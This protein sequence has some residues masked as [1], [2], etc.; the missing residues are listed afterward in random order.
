M[1]KKI[2]SLALAAL[3]VGACFVGCDNY[4]DDDD[5]RDTKSSVSSKKDKDDDDEKDSDSKDEDY[6]KDKMSS[7]N[8]CAKATAN[9]TN[10]T[11]VELDEFGA[12][13]MF[14]GWID[15]SDWDWE[16]AEKYNGGAEALTTD[17]AEEL[18]AGIIQ[19]YFKDISKLDE[20]AIYIEKG[21][22]SGV[23]CSENGEFWGTYPPELITFEDYEDGDIDA[24]ECIDRIE[25]TIK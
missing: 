24:Q 6:I 23:Y 10:T 12:D 15:L 16:N 1:K 7:A 2:I 14:T 19:E 9:A 17:N 5:E 22:C 8:Y 13:V 25:K 3:C 21:I 4:D 18:L 11:L 20:V